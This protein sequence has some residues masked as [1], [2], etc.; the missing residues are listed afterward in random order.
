[1]ED[2]IDD[3]SLPLLSEERVDLK[4]RPRSR[5]K[6][7]D[8][9]IHPAQSNFARADAVALQLGLGGE[10][11]RVQGFMVPE[12]SAWEIGKG[13]DLAREMLLGSMKKTGS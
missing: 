11:E 12:A 9:L 13:K 7:D 1:M 2:D 4:T 3:I 8:I 5:S 6:P 10:T